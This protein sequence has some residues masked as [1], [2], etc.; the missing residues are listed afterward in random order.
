MHKLYIPQPGSRDA[1]LS[2]AV[3]SLMTSR[4]LSGHPFAVE[5]ERQYH[6]GIT[7]AKHYHPYS[8]THLE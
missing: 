5:Y 8:L 3:V 1:P 7:Y 6:T 4:R 2:E